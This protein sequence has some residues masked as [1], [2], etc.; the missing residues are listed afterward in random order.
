MATHIEKIITELREPAYAREEAAHKAL[1][2]A[3]A[4]FAEAKAYTESVDAV[5][6]YLKTMGGDTDFEPSG[7]EPFNP[8]GNEPFKPS[9]M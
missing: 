6:D 9:G 4:R 7:N 8:S 2:R 5:V 3:E 1:L